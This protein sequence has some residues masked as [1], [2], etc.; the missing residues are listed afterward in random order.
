MFK[1]LGIV[2]ALSTALLFGSGFSSA[3]DSFQQVQSQGK[4]YKVYY[5]INWKSQFI[6]EDK[7]NDHQSNSVNKVQLSWDDVIERFQ[8]LKQKDNPAE[9]EAPIEEDDPVKNEPVE[10]E[11]PD[12]NQEPTNDA[13]QPAETPVI[14]DPTNEEVVEEQEQKKDQAQTEL[15]QFEQQ[16]VDLTNEE[17]AEQGLPTLKVDTELSKVAREKS[18]DMAVNR[19]FSHNSP[20]YGSPFDMLSQFGVDYRTA[21]ENIA[22]GQR[23]PEEVVN[24]WMNSPGHR[25]NILNANFTHIGVGYVEDGN[26]WTQMFIG[27]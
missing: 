16:V 15:N 7:V 26:Y 18:K 20:T 11:I 17:R 23:T 10:V 4:V 21:G 22:R 12:D 19:Y 9:N 2:T 27:K 6:S 13:E 5:S 14:E 25:A 1:K 24:A 8:Q 3:S